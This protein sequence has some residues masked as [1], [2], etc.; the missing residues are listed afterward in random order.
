MI[1]LPAAADGYADLNA[2]GVII[3]GRPAAGP[4][5]GISELYVA[6]QE[7]MREGDRILIIIKLNN[8][9]LGE[10]VRGG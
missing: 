7:A 9:A 1:A 10:R 5:I 6:W 2:A 3:Q 8:P 4:Q